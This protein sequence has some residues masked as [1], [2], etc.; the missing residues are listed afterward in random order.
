MV[1]KKAAQH[2]RGP[3]KY[4]CAQAILKAFEEYC[5]AINDETI[6]AFKN[7]GGG[8]A[9]GGLCGALFAAEQ[10]VGDAESIQLLRQRFLDAVG[11]VVCW[12]IRKLKRC[13]CEQCVELAAEILH[14]IAG[15]KKLKLTGPVQSD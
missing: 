7:F 13:S 3:E 1:V 12:E 14:D 15:D 10:L 5:D 2:F 8:R 9:E 6:A 11:S 4:G